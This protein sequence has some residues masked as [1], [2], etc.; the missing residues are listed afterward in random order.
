MSKNRRELI[1]ANW[2]ARNGDYGVPLKVS[3]QIGC[4]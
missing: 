1:A 4:V 2:L 3:A